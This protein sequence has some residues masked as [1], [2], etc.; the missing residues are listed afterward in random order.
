MRDTGPELYCA[1]PVCRR[2]G[3]R[4]RR[5][6]GGLVPEGSRPLPHPVKA[7]NHYRLHAGL[8]RYTVLPGLTERALGRELEALAGVELDYWP[9]FDR[10]DLH[11]RAGEREFRVDV[12]DHA[13]P[14]TLLRSLEN[15][16]ADWIVIP[17]ERRDQIAT[18]QERGPRHIG[19]A[20]LSDFVDRIRRLV[21]P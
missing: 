8:W 10:Y 18:L 6:D 17:D 21:S 13:S 20:T 1:S 16:P 4:F 15:E 14:L 2:D 5:R 11:I 3:A 7:A 12:K 19:F 9:D